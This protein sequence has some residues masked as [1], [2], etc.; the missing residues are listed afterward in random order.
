M[1]TFRIFRISLGITLSLVQCMYLSTCRRN[2]HTLL[3]FEC[4]QRL[5]IQ[6][7][8]IKMVDEQSSPLLHV[9]EDVEMAPFQMVAQDDLRNKLEI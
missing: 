8:T 7:A 1:I 9:D 2:K 6:V 4:Y 3:I 5:R